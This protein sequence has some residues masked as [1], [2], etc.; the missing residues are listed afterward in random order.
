V[1]FL[2]Q[3]LI[4]LSQDVTV[5]VKVFKNYGSPT[6]E[7]EQVYVHRLKTDKEVIDVTTVVFQ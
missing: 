5:Q 6:L 1:Q 7:T 3:H 4:L 2:R